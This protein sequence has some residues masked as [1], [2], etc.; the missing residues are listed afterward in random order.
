MLMCFSQSAV[1]RG[2]ALC[3]LE[4]IAP[5]VKHARRHY[6][7]VLGQPFR[8][9]VD[10]EEYVYYDKVDNVKYCT[11]VVRWIISKASNQVLI[12]LAVHR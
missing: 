8:E 12:R 7:F 1:V 3:G 5:R 9:G 10:P 4:G 2:A 6:G 11:N